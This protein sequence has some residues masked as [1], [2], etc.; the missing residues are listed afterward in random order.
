MNNNLQSIT[1]LR[2]KLLTEYVEKL[3]YNVGDSVLWQRP[4]EVLLARLASHYKEIRRVY[5]GE[6]RV[7]NDVNIPSK[8]WKY[9]GRYFMA[10]NHQQDWLMERQT[11]KWLEVFYE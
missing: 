3:R 11:V 8:L 2:D 10:I 7:T 6:V 4:E 9:Q 5:T 1:F